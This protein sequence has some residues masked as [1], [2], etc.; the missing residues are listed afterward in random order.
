MSFRLVRNPSEE[1]CWTSQHE[2][3]KESPQQRLWGIKNLMK[4]RYREETDFGK[5]F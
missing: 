1:R 5:F 4:R 3:N 2:R